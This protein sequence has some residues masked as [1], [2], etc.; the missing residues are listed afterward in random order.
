M[1]D[2]YKVH[3]RKVIVWFLIVFLCLGALFSFSMHH[4]KDANQEL[5]E[6]LKTEEKDDNGIL[7][8]FPSAE[9]RRL[10]RHVT[11]HT[12]FLM[13]YIL[14]MVVLFIY[15]LYKKC[16]IKVDD[17]GVYLYHFF[18]MKQNNFFPWEKIKHVRYGV[19]RGL[20][21]FILH[22][23]IELSTVKEYDNKYTVSL[24]GFRKKKELVDILRKKVT[25]EAFSQD[26]EYQKN[27]HSFYHLIQQSITQLKE[28]Y[29]VFYAFSGLI[30]IFS[31]MN[32]FFQ[33]T[34]IAFLALIGTVYF[35]YK[36]RVAINY[37]AYNMKREELDFNTCFDRT[38]G[39]VWRFFGAGLFSGIIGVIPVV[40]GLYFFFVEMSLIVKG[41]LLSITTLLYL[42]VGI[43]TVL[44]PYIA[45]ITPKHVSYFT[46]NAH[47]IK[48][49][50]KKLL[51]II[52]LKNIIPAGM[53]G[54]LLYHKDNLLE[55]LT[56]LKMWPYV[57]SGI[58][59]IILPL[60]SV[61]VVNIFAHYSPLKEEEDVEK[62]S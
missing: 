33:G 15:M 59:F 21:S 57:L 54:Y 46:I 13:I 41:V 36:S 38:N 7:R 60:L 20:K 23:A 27:K 24:R 34:G 47:I 58:D 52:L 32:N 61:L 48:K 28:K 56:K 26:V 25:K 50:Y 14:S 39:R 19:S 4:Y 18:G 30:L 62:V 10:S 35:G 11:I 40:L 9:E 43:G 17:Q 42:C 8:F 16:K 44:L 5:Q 53:I 37:L 55:A 1:Q 6:Y 2:I 22:P 12:F 29:T 45:S 31:L 49:E 51:V 3:L